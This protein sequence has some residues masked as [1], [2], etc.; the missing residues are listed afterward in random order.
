MRSS[1]FFVAAFVDND[2]F[3]GHSSLASATDSILEPATR[4]AIAIQPGRR[5]RR[6]GVQRV[7][8]WRW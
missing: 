3:T 7:P 8:V 2:H 5:V 4:Y 6:S 1:I